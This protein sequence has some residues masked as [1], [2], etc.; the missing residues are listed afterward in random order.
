LSEIR[1]LGLLEIALGC[2]NMFYGHLGL[3]FWTA[4][5]G[6]LHIVYGLIMWWKYEKA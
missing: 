2:I 5:F 6:F 4:G 1:Y 3:Y